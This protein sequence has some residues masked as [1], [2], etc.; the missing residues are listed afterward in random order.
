MLKFI[1]LLGTG[2]YVPCNY[3]I[4]DN[5]VKDCCY[6]QQALIEILK[7][8]DMMPDSIII[9]TTE[10]A[11]QS[12]WE[13]NKYGNNRLG[14]KDELENIS[15]NGNC[16]IKNKFI[17][18]GFNEDELWDIF[19]SILDEIEEGDEII[20]DI[21]HSFRYLPMLTFIV[22]NYGRIIKK[23]NIKAIYYGAFET[24]GFKN[25]VEDMPLEE[26][27]APIFDL[28]PFVHLFD[29][30][31][32]VD[33]Y[34][35]TGDASM[36]KELTDL[37][38]KKINN[39]I[40]KNIKGK[41]VNRNILFKDPN[42]I[43]NLANSMSTFSDAVSTCRGPELTNIISQL[44][45]NIDNVL[46]STAHERI[47]PLTPIIQILKERF[48]RFSLN[49]DYI[50]MIETAKWCYDNEMY[51]QGFTIL[52]EGLISY[53]CEKWHLD[54][55]NKGSRSQV[56][57]YSYMIKDGTV[58][59]DY[60]SIEMTQENANQ[61]FILIYEMVNVR[62]DINHAGWR[63]N[64]AGSNTFKNNLKDFI[65]RA[66]VILYNEL[67]DAENDVKEKQMLLIFS[68]QLTEK[69]KEEAKEKFSISQFIEL[70]SK[71]LDKWANIPPDLED[72]TEYIKDILEWIDEKSQIGDYV[73]V[74]GDYGATNF[75]VDYCKSKGLIPVYATTKRKVTEQKLGEVIRSSREFEHV[76]FRRY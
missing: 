48:N 59:P 58:N 4:G 60:K 16:K 75:V 68:H 62:N 11:Y 1:S 47:K 67:K 73:L 28:I 51:Q 24:L 55:F 71:L 22:I 10:Y 18:E 38:I 66:E 5:L 46:E 32:A 40:N 17:P 21:T 20:L 50:N 14:L 15:Q 7:A 64:L 45:Q 70:D 39:E 65:N 35:A 52:Q 30:T 56:I 53:V 31:I 26:R 37:E 36:V 27:N 3:Y 74:Q 49:D 19:K 6:I 54:K 25:V 72:L 42:S 76:M 29:W 13:K 12:N 2:G 34:I 69:Q 9:F 41:N 43:R 61:L 44:K 57:N 8:Q 63:E 23:C 33:R